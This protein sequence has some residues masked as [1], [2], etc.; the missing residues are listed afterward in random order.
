[1]SKSKEYIIVIPPI[2][3]SEQKIYYRKKITLHIASVCY[4]HCYAL[5][6]KSQRNKT[7][8]EGEKIFATR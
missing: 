5:E 4:L 1:M 2:I 7:E 6:G 8:F 3:D